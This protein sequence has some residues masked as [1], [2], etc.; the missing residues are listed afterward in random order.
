MKFSEC[1]LSVPLAFGGVSAGLGRGMRATSGLDDPPPNPSPLTHLPRRGQGG[2]GPGKAY[3]ADRVG[4]RRRTRRDT[5]PEATQRR[6]RRLLAQA[7]VSSASSSGPSTARG[8]DPPPP[9]SQPLP[10]SPPPL[11]PPPLK[12]RA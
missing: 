7:T 6:P 8:E 1:E 3:A 2:R 11:A 5:K 4:Q 9:R 12:G 10:R